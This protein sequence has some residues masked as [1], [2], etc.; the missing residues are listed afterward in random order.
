M[1]RGWQEFSKDPALD[2]PIRDTSSPLN[3]ALIASGPS[4]PRERRSTHQT[5]AHSF[6]HRGRLYGPRKLA[7]ARKSEGGEVQSV[8]VPCLLEVF[9]LVRYPTNMPATCR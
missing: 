9:L 6:H 3:F 1:R 4:V 8:Q 7:E 2:I 5:P